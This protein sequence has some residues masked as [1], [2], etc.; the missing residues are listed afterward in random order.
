MN[1]TFLALAATVGLAISPLARA[2]PVT[3]Q[4]DVSIQMALGK[5]NP[6][7]DTVIAA[8][9]FDNW[10]TTLL[11]LSPSA[12]NP[13][14]YMGTYNDTADPVGGTMQYKYILNSGGT[15]NWESRNNR[16]ATLASS[17][18]TLPVIYFNDVSTAATGGLITFNVNMKVQRELG[19]FNPDTDTVI[20]AGT[21][22]NWSATEFALTNSPANTNIYSGTYNDV[23]ESPGATVQYKFIISSTTSGLNWEGINN[24]S[25]TLPSVNTNLPVV[26]F[27]NLTN[28]PGTGVPVTYQVNMG[29][30]AATGRFIPGTD[31]VVVA[32]TFNNWST[33][34][35]SLTNSP[36]EPNL[37]R[38]T[39]NDLNDAPGN[40]AQ[41]KFVINSGNWETINN[42]MFTLASTNQSLAMV[43]FN[44]LND[45]GLLSVSS[46]S[47]GQITLSWTGAPGIR[48]QTSTNL[49]AWS[50]V[51]NTT[52]ADAATVR[53]T[54]AQQFFRLAG[55]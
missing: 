18:Q 38:G 50:D 4:V 35:S 48:L 24:R 40:I 5:F 12:S 15:L 9:S 16:T 3:F 1:R 31:S 13:N 52:G 20:C 11:V 55:P 10:S 30:W 54:S 17:A 42:R 2:V 19:R 33:T 26:F 21:F 7:S 34:A 47:S 32:G 41:F 39:F 53:M 36:T 28:N 49:K 37:Y 43:F 46:V 51:D 25:F 14:I 45:L 44:N 22:D 27:N 6:G 23:N 8:G 29:V